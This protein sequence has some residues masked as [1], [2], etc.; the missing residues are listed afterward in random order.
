MIPGDHM[1]LGFVFS[2]LIYAI[3]PQIGFLGLFVMFLASIFIDIDHY[4][5]YVKAKK[6]WSLS[7]AFKWYEVRPTNISEFV[8]KTF[9]PF[10]GIEFLLILAGLAYLANYFALT[11]IFNMILSVLLGCIIHLVLDW[12][13]M[14]YNKDPLYLKLSFIYC[15]FKHKSLLRSENIKPILTYLENQKV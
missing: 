7:N 11:F 15:Y 6:D 8:D 1:L 10:H 5:A 14:I 9:Y 4:L 3:L 13:Y 12:G 2:L